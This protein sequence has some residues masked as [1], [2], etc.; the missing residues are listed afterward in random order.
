MFPNLASSYP[1]KEIYSRDI[2]FVPQSDPLFK[3]L[4]R[5]YP[6][7]ASIMIHSRDRSITENDERRLRELKPNIV[8]EINEGVDKIDRTIACE[9]TIAGISVIEMEERLKGEVPTK[10]TG[11][12]CGCTFERGWR[13]WIVNVRRTVTNPRGNINKEL[14]MAIYNDPV[15]RKF[16]RTNGYAGNQ[17][18][19]I[20]GSVTFYHIDSQ[21]G[22]NTFVKYAKMIADYQEKEN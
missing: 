16:I 7:P 18:P 20:S 19:E 4:N 22:L 3:E 8:K 14:A 12:I 6:A 5:C 21:E 15:G 1:A 13:Y 2:L 10:Y 9:L 17:S 11:D